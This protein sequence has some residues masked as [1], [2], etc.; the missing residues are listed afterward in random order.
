MD[1]N[2]YWTDNQTIFSQP[3][4]TVLSPLVDGRDDGNVAH[5]YG[6][7]QSYMNIRLFTIFSSG[8][9]ARWDEHEKLLQV[10]KIF[11]NLFIAVLL[12]CKVLVF[13]YFQFSWPKYVSFISAA[14]F[15][16]GTI[17]QRRATWR[18]VCCAA[19]IHIFWKKNRLTMTIAFKIC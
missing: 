18:H 7:W 11:N 13:F 9:T 12:N 14:K 6:G 2:H 15:P 5:G 17:F 4:V 3:I 19:V 10:E 8:F 1:T 16:F